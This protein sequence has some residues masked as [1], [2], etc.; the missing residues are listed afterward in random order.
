MTAAGTTLPDC[1]QTPRRGVTADKE[2]L[3][4]TSL[5][6]LLPQLDAQRFWPVHRGTVARA[7]LSARC[8]TGR[9]GS[10]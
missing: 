9:A 3:I 5:K 8:V 2:H 4:R 10:R 1:A 6:E 7:R